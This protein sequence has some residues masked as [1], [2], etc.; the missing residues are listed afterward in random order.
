MGEDVALGRS[1]FAEE[2]KEINGAGEIAVV[3]V[4]FCPQQVAAERK[5]PGERNTW[6][7]GYIR[8]SRG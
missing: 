3:R 6:D 8:H 4:R 1:K 2:R 5:K 7:M